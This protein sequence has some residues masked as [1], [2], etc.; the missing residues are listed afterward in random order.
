MTPLRRALTLLTVGLLALALTACGGGGGDDVSGSGTTVGSAGSPVT[1][2]T[3]TSPDLSFD[4]TTVYV[5]AGVPVTLTY[6][7]QHT[8]VP[9]NLHVTGTGVDEMTPI[10]PGPDV[11]TITVTFPEP[12]EYG[13]VCDVHSSMTGT[14]IA[15]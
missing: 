8:G 3:I 5:P 2:A 10:R 15:V 1:E 4:V 13:Y 11:S 9:H 6:D 14:V 12:G 7:N